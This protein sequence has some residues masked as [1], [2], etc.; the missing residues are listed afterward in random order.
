M[1]AGG[2]RERVMSDRE[3]F[4]AA[5]A[6]NPD[7]DLPRLEHLDLSGTGLREV[8]DSLGERFGERVTV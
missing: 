8:P 6:A 4:V 2:H 5:V 7:D 1:M 3:A